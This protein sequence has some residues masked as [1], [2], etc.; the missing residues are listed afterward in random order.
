MVYRNNA[1]RQKITVLAKL[2]FIHLGGVAQGIGQAFQQIMG[3]FQYLG[4]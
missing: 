4:W 2:D 3:D 1:L